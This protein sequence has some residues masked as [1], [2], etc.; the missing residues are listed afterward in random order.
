[1]KNKN[2]NITIKQ[3]HDEDD[4]EDLEP[5]PHDPTKTL[6]RD[7]TTRRRPWTVTVRPDEDLEP[8][9]HDP[10]SKLLVNYRLTTS[11]RVARPSRQWLHLSDH[12]ALV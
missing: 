2:T 12:I 8:W 7:R 9:P 10:E 5:W 11:L 4:D 1:M 3:I 6:N